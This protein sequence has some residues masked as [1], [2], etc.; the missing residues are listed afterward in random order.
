MT[1]GNRHLI[2]VKRRV[3][4]TQGVKAAGGMM[5]GTG[6]KEAKFS[7]SSKPSSYHHP[8]GCFTPPEECP[9]QQPTN[10]TSLD[11]LYPLQANRGTGMELDNQSTALAD[12]PAGYEDDAIILDEQEEPTPG[13]QL[14]DQPED[15]PTSH[16][17]NAPILDDPK[18]PDPDIEL[19][20]GATE[21]PK[22]PTSHGAD[23]IPVLA[24]S[25]GSD[26]R[27][28]DPNSTS[29]QTLPP[30]SIGNT[31]SNSFLSITNTITN[32]PG[33]PT[34]MT[35][36]KRILSSTETHSESTPIAT[37]SKRRIIDCS[38]WCRR[39]TTNEDVSHPNDRNPKQH[40]F[41][42]D[43]DESTSQLNCPFNQSLVT[44][45]SNF[46]PQVLLPFNTTFAHPLPLVAS[47][48]IGWP[49]QPL[50]AYPVSLGLG[51][52][53]SPISFIH[54]TSVSHPQ[55][56]STPFTLFPPPSDLNTQTLDMSA[57]LLPHETPLTIENTTQHPIFTLTRP[58]EHTSD[59]SR[60]STRPATLAFRHPPHHANVSTSRS[61]DNLREPSRTSRSASTQPE[62]S[63]ASRNSLEPPQRLTQR[64][65]SRA[66]SLT[67]NDSPRLFRNSSD[68]SSSNSSRG[69]RSTS[70]RHRSTQGSTQASTSHRSPSPSPSPSSE[71]SSESDSDSGS[72]SDLDIRQRQHYQ[73]KEAR[74]CSKITKSRR[75]GV[76][77]EKLTEDQGPSK[78]EQLSICIQDYFKLILGVTRKARGEKKT[79]T[80]PSPPSDKEITAWEQRKH[81]RKRTIAKQVSKERERFLKYNSAPKRAELKM[82]DETATKKAVEKL[83]PAALASGGFPRCTFDWQYSLQSKWNEAMSTIMLQEWEKCY[84]RGDASRYLINSEH[85][86]SINK[87]RIFERWYNTQR[88]NFSDQVRKIS[89]TENNASSDS[90]NVVVDDK[91]ARE[92]ISRSNS[93]KRVSELRSATFKKYFPEER[94]LY[95]IISDPKVHSED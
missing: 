59:P 1:S 51:S 50:P 7:S 29:C 47:Q 17:E 92:K 77:F 30:H 34:D 16:E 76:R 70:R 61:T 95:L 38:N 55:V 81:D 94:N 5:K 11:N 10:F 12:H 2:W 48:P 8:I 19:D 89:N 88:A 68:Y 31:H 42:G 14:D 85:V 9:M 46:N 21:P 53:S 4:S 32:S 80:L 62:S 64:S 86:T 49:A 79:S 91:Q 28:C 39:Y 6:T 44:Q 20:D 41:T 15:H 71:A 37:N 67:E 3:T 52:T 93:R 58:T 74:H 25:E 43:P 75:E 35:P 72:E 87:F 82:I 22:Y 13:M 65:L 33:P 26:L 84:N 23:T 73:R 18:G 45:N 56:S 27:N 83:K 78:N 24:H 36:S 66:D 57:P 54:I 63:S 90:T 69:Q 40:H 60:T